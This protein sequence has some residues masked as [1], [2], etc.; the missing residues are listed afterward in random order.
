MWPRHDFTIVTTGKIKL[1]IL[2]ISFEIVLVKY[3]KTSYITVYLL[4]SIPCN[5]V[6]AA[7][8]TAGTCHSSGPRLGCG[9]GSSLWCFRERTAMWH[10]PRAAWPLQASEESCPSETTTP[11]PVY[12]SG[13]STKRD[14]DQK[15]AVWKLVRTDVRLLTS[16]QRV[17]ISAG[18][19]F[20][21]NRY[22]PGGREWSQT[23]SCI[24]VF[25]SSVESKS[26]LR[27]A[28]LKVLYPPG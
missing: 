26:T 13:S 25:W 12:H 28:F 3:W 20:M 11:E 7:G 19:L 17:G 8:S 22:H 4:H 5:L 23:R 14:G 16:T 24:A 2:G 9:K 18:L 15:T 6:S 27:Y 10:R 1:F 21:E